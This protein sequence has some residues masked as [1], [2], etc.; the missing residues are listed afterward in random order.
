MAKKKTK[1]TKKPSLTQILKEETNLAPDRV[2]VSVGLRLQPIQFTSAG[3]D[4]TLESTLRLGESHDDG[5]ARVT[6]SVE[7]FFM[8]EIDTMFDKLYDY[9]ATRKKAR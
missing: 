8:G 3:F 6:K 2:T 4:V 7:S 9:A 5:M 1:V